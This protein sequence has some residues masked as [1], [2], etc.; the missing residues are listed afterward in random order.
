MKPLCLVWLLAVIWSCG[1]DNTVQPEEE[2][3]FDYESFSK[4]YAAA[5]LPYQ[6]S[7]TG[8]LKNKDTV[9]IA[10]PLF[11]PFVADSITKKIFGKTTGIRYIPL[12]MLE[13]DEESYF[14][15]KA[16]SGNKTAALLTVFGKDRDSAASFPFLVPD[17]DAATT[18][19]ST[20][21]NALSVSRSVSRKEKDNT[22]IDGKDVYA[23]N[24]AANI[25]TLVLTDVLDEGVQELVNPIDTLPRKHSLSGD[26]GTGKKNIVSIRDG[27]NATE[28]NM[29]I[30]FEKEEGECIGELKGTLLLTSTTTAVYRQGGDACVLEFQF[31][32]N[33]VTLREEEGCGAHRGLKCLFDGSYKRKAVAR[34]KVVKKKT[35]KK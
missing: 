13:K 28:L 14:I 9:R 17:A 26:Y 10:A 6:L 33:T 8:L 5:P 16:I 29:F 32:S 4:R 34:P 1:N 21:D 30:H 31:A 25:F 11:A 35:L 2:S 7:D 22:T 20:I 18:Q 19:V 3:T 12:R 27:R 23:Y 15:T 24:A